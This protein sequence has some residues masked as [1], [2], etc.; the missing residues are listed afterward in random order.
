MKLNHRTFKTPTNRTLEIT[1]VSSNYHVEINPSDV[2]SG[3]RFVVQEVIKEMAQSG[4]LT[5]STARASMAAASSSSSSSSSSAAAASASAGPAKPQKAPFKVVVLTDVDRLSRDAQAALRRTMELYTSSCR[6]VLICE[7]ASRVIE[8]VRS[9]CLALRIAAPTAPEI[10]KVLD[11]VARK[12][13]IDLP[14]PFAAKIARASERNLRR[15]ILM[16]EASKVQQ[17]PFTATQ[18]PQTMDWQR[19]IEAMAGEIASAPNPASLL[20]A[21]KKLYELLINCIPSDVI[22]RTLCHYLCLRAPNDFARHQI[23]SWA[24][25]MEVRLRAG[26]KEIFH[27]EAFVA[28]AM[29]VLKAVQLEMSKQA[30]ASAATSASSSAAAAASASSV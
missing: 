9:R 6:L 8:P 20:G 16:L 24:T 23:V 4:S 25:A 15:A 11:Q 5:A 26:S 13:G 21:R 28:R 30:T 2:G 27:L 12:E 7:S 22:L 10:M 14:K 19:Y 3:D 18:M 1:T 17:Y 29:Q